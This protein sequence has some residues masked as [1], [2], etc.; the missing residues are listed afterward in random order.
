[1]LD[2]ALKIPSVAA[3]TVIG[4]MTAARPPATPIA[5]A[6]PMTPATLGTSPMKFYGKP[7]PPAMNICSGWA[8]SVKIAAIPKCK[9]LIINKEYV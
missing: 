7:A 6:G 3:P 4:S 2:N 5:G 8:I 1:M 9:N